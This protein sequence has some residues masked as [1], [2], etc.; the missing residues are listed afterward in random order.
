[1]RT[2]MTSFGTDNIGVRAGSVRVAFLPLPHVPHICYAMHPIGFTSSG[3][4]LQGT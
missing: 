1:M 3:N 2:N 4:G